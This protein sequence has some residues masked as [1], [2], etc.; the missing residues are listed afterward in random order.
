MF[1]N[2]RFERVLVVCLGV[3]IAWLAGL[4]PPIAPKALSAE[5]SN[6]V[7]DDT[8]LMFVGLDLEV[9]TIASRREESASQAP[10]VADVIT[11]DQIEKSGYSTLAELLGMTP[12]FYMAPKEW[13]SQPYLRGLP[14]SALF[15]YD[16]V[17]MH[18]NI[19]KSVHPLDHEL[20]LA[21]V[22][23]IEIIR[24]PGSVLW[25][26]D[27]Y[28]G[29]VNIVPMT[30]KDIDKA[31]TGVLYNSHGDQA[32]GY[33]N[34]GHNSGPWD[35]FFSVSGRYGKED[36]RHFDIVRFWGDGE[37]PVSPEARFGRRRPDEAKYLDMSGRLAYGDQFALTARF[38]D[39]EKPYTIEARNAGVWSESRS[40]PFSFVKAESKTDLD[41]HS[42][43]R[44]M[45][46]YSTVHSDYEVID[47]SYSRMNTPI[48]QK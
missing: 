36:D 32:G 33:L 13:G 17:P 35:M 38:S 20:S 5:T 37:N 26:P 16:T 12:G 15:L 6:Q 24:G 30:G 48:T 14:N 22:K 29:I 28:G 39:F 19:R 27:A 44:L 11:R 41:A 46:Y 25:G 10:A 47:K 7:A 23:R 4:V 9:L 34:A 43:I 18:S 40:T 45:G 3:W 8:M 31:E 21:P 1:M 42:A 2:R